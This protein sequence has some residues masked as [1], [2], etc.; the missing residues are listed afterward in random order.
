M[1]GDTTGLVEDYVSRKFESGN[2][3]FFVVDGERGPYSFRIRPIPVESYSF[4]PVDNS[5]N[6]VPVGDWTSF[7][8]SFSKEICCPSSS[9]SSSSSTAVFAITEQPKNN[10]SATL[11]D[12]AYFFVTATGI[13]TLL[14]QWQGFYYDYN[15][16]NYGWNDISGAT[17]STFNLS[18]NSASNYGIDTY[19]TGG[20]MQLRVVVTDAADAST[21]T[22]QVVRW[23]DYSMISPYADFYGNSGSYPSGNTPGGG[24]LLS[25]QEDETVNVNISD[26]SMTYFDT[27]WYSSNAFTVKL[28]T[29]TTLNQWTDVETFNARG[30]GFYFGT[31]L[32]AQYGVVWYRVVVITN[33]PLTVTNGT[34]N[35]G[36]AGFQTVIA[37]YELTWPPLTPKIFATYL[38]AD[39]M[40]SQPETNIVDTYLGAD[41]MATQRDTNI[42]DTYL[43]VD[44]LCTD[45]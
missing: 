10:F 5:G 3:T 40:A 42:V 9:S 43:G 12:S 13:G 39:V 15:T 22:S 26:Y 34:L 28:Q 35:A 24:V 14:Y 29:A 6:P 16:G 36:R 7:S 8:G 31:T 37:S 18:S 2:S 19:S 4:E 25:L 1:L 27:S 21:L 20:M 30:S 23:I 41:V 45:N 32:A 11:S 44:V 33:W 38:G 17:A